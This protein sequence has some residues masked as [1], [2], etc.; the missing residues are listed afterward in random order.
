[1]VESFTKC[2]ALITDGSSI[3]Y[4]FFVTEKPILYLRCG[5]SF[6]LHDHCFNII[7]SYH[8]IGDEFNQIEK[9]VDMVTSNSYPLSKERSDKFFQDA[10]I[11]RPVSIGRKI[12]EFVEK[13][14]ISL[15]EV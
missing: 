12:K 3:M 1:M 15:S 4:D 9:F 13:E 8:H 11:I 6:K 7:K 2:D 14:L 5:D 10:A